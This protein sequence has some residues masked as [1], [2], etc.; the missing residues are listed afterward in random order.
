MPKTDIKTKFFACL[1]F[2]DK[3]RSCLSDSRSFAVLRMTGG[4]AP[5]TIVRNCILVVYRLAF[6]DVSCYTARSFNLIASNP[7]GAAKFACGEFGSKETQ[8]MQ[9]IGAF[10][11]SEEPK[12]K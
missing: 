7:S 3:L 4:E 12:I 10:V 6:D 2:T 8:Q 11:V 1:S 5:R 9:R